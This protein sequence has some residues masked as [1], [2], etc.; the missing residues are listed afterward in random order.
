MGKSSFMNMNEGRPRMNF[1]DRPLVFI[2]LELTGLDLSTHE[3]LEIGA[4]VTSQSSLEILSEHSIKVR[5][6]RI[7]DADPRALEII[8]YSDEKWIGAVPLPAAL[9]EFNKI[10]HDGMLAGWNI[11]FDWSFLSRDFDALQIKPDFDYHFIDVLPI[12]YLTFR[13]QKDPQTL[14]L[15]TVARM[16]GISVPE[17]HGALADARA[18]FE[19]YKALIS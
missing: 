11:P 7:D 17:V 16:L 5:P 13:N 12:S 4:V 19:I 8:E 6:D 15:R 10:S 1:R 9:N 3:I 14:A 18:S 2:D